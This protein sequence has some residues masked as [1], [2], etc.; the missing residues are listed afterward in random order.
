MGI[1]RLKEFWP[2]WETGEVLGKGSFGKVYK[3]FNRSSGVTNHSAIKVITIPN[4]EA[5]YDALLNE[6]MSVPDTKEYFRDIVNEF[7]NEIKVMVALKGAP[8]I[9]SVE[10]YKILENK[11][12]VGWDIFIR[13]E[14]LHSF[15]EFLN[16]HTPSE[17]EI[18]RM[19][20]DIANALEICQSKNIIHRDIKPANIFM[21]DYG[22]FRLGDFGIA[23]ELEKTTGAASA[24]GTFTF[25]APEVAHG[26]RYDNTVDIYSLGLVMYTLLNGNRAPFVPADGRVT[27]NDRKDANDKRLAGK[28][29]P[30]IMGISD[31]LNNIILTAC[32]YD[33]QR[34]FKSATAFKNALKSLNYT[35]KAPDPKTELRTA[36][37]DETVALYQKKKEAPMPEPKQKIDQ[38]VAVAHKAA[39]KPAEENKEEIKKPEKKKKKGIIIAVALLLVL[40]IAAAVVIPALVRRSD[41]PIEEENLAVIKSENYTVTPGMLAYVY[42]HDIYSFK[43]N[44]DAFAAYLAP[45]QQ[46]P[47][48][49]KSLSGQYYDYGTTSGTPRTWHEYFLDQ[50]LTNIK[51]ALCYAEEATAR[52]FE[53]AELNNDIERH[54]NAIVN[55]AEAVGLSTEELITKLYTDKVSENDI[56][57]ILRIDLFATAYLEDIKAKKSEQISEDQLEAYKNDHAEDLLTVDYYSFTF[58]ELD[59]EAAYG[60]SDEQRLAITAQAEADADALVATLN[61]EKDLDAKI[62]KFGEWVGAYLTQA[63]LSSETPKTNSEL[64]ADIE[65]KTSEIKNQRIYNNSDDFAKWASIDERWA[66]DAVSIE[67]GAGIYTVYLLTRAASTDDSPTKN[68][69]QIL[70]TVDEYGSDNAAMLKAEEILNEYL[71]GNAGKDSFEEI[72]RKYN[73]YGSTFYYNVKEGTMVDE[74]NDWIFDEVRKEGD[75]DIVKTEY[76]YHVMYFVGEGLP[77]WKAVAIEDI[78]NEEMTA[79]EESITDKHMDS[80]E[81][82]DSLIKELPDLLPF[83]EEAEA[84]EAVTEA[85]AVEHDHDSNGVADNEASVHDTAVKADEPKSDVSTEK[86]WT[87]YFDP[88]GGEMVGPTEYGVNCDDHFADIFG[89]TIPQATLEGYVLVGWYAEKWNF[90]LTDADITGGGYYG[91]SEDCYFVALWEEAPVKSD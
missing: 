4:D 5:E 34:R 14:L 62:D 37:I 88:D 39:S 84:A 28:P 80:I 54:I 29:L 20:I 79:Y 72:S 7:I 60:L 78:L 47:D 1:E 26:Q 17:A 40:A 6:G 69:G 74:F 53:Y 57:E 85:P 51:T 86:D 33:P 24:K 83:N 11:E 32:A 31:E 12:R 43:E 77:A 73:D 23:K 18:V 41:K 76:G 58:G 52:G 75:T 65:A 19:G 42:Y 55:E 38:T 70:I 90:T 10:D 71:N 22:S 15:K 46:A 3:A 2:E 64:G 61:S 8:N 50:S 16:S 82:D 87:M 56:R 91:I 45:S 44:Y 48:F 36:S 59:T 89:E 9:V 66:G 13:M 67:T 81:T 68:V 21:D 30:R 27:Y 25:M 35:V 49:S 63:N